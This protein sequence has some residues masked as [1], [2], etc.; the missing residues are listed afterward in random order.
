MEG[1]YGINFL[2]DLSKG[3][4]ISL[5]GKVELFLTVDRTHQVDNDERRLGCLIDDIT[6]QT[7]QVSSLNP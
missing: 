5:K 4:E 2:E 1:L 6:V 7:G 3:T